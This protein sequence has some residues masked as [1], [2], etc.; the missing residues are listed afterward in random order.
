MWV[1]VLFDLPTDT[2]E[3]RRDYRLFRKALLEDGFIMLQFSVYAR[4]CPSPENAEVHLRRVENTLPPEGQVRILQITGKQFERM[5]IFEGE[6]RQEP[7]R[8]ASQ[9]QLF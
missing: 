8:E 1:I 7:E 5:K 2:P 3:A 6:I 9:L 4:C